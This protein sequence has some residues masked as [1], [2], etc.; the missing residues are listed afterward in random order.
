[1]IQQ[2]LNLFLCDLLKCKKA[3]KS[4]KTKKHIFQKNTNTRKSFH[5]I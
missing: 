5:F 3:T 1:L 2:T 4:T